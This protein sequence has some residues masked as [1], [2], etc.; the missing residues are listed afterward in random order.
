MLK[1]SKQNRPFYRL[2]K[3]AKPGQMMCLITPEV[4]GSNPTVQP[5]NPQATRGVERSA[6]VFVPSSN[7]RLDA[8]GN[9]KVEV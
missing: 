5:Q 8:P 1:Q 2:A 3:L 9:A 6:P 7:V 4:V